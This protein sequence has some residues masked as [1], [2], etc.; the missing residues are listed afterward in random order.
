M[1]MDML[2]L[3]IIVSSITSIGGGCPSGNMSFV[4][5]CTQAPFPYTRCLIIDIFSSDKSWW[6]RDD[7]QLLNNH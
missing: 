6:D 3:S 7:I 1:M 2:G 5:T 4:A